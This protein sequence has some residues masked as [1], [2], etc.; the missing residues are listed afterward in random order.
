[1]KDPRRDQVAFGVA[2]PA[3]RGWTYLR[4]IFDSPVDTIASG[5][6]SC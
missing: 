5:Y 4:A 3:S 1:M 6:R 2:A